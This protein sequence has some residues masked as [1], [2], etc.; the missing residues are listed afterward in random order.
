MRRCSPATW[1]RSSSRPR[2]DS[3][4]S[5]GQARHG[6]VS[7]ISQPRDLFQLRQLPRPVARSS[8]A[9]T[10]SAA[11]EQSAARSARA[12]RDLEGDQPPGDRRPRDGRPGHSVR[13]A[14]V[15]RLVRHQPGPQGRRVRPRGRKKLLAEAGYPDGF[16]L[17]IHGPNDRYVNDEKIVQAV[18][19]M[20]T[21]VGI[22]SKVETRRWAVPS[23]AQSSN[24]RVQL[25]LVGWGARH[26][27]GVSPLRSL[28]ATV[29][30]RRGLARSTGAATAIRRS[31]T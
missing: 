3:R 16:D 31:T 11:T 13:P 14:R 10:A 2:A 1:T 26:G 17:T 22:V 6:H 18:A 23:R 4:G 15:R 24:A 19:Q 21:R 5:R 30:P 28:L 8:P 27:R 20:L 7:Q 25:P 12:P 9:R 29:E